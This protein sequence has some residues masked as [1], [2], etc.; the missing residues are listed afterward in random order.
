MLAMLAAFA[1][2]A[3]EQVVLVMGDSLSAAYGLRPEQGWVALADAKSDRYTFR[4]ASVSGETTAGGRSRIDAE[5]AR[6]RPDIVIIELG[7]N[8]GL[9]G[10][11]LEQMGAN[12]GGMIGRSRA[13]GARVLL[14]GLQLPP[15]FGPYAREFQRSYVLIRPAP[16]HRAGAAFP[17]PA[18]HRAALVPGRQPA[19]HGAGAAAAG[20]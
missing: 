14:V 18:G 20:R 8:D 6:T 4:N 2:Q 10:L 5:L 17:R 15:N 16:A 9:R 7:A 1:A 3:R 13:A 11:P 19:P 12:L